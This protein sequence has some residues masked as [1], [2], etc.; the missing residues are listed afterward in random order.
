MGV[1][2]RIIQIL[3]SSGTS[4]EF[5]SLMC[6]GVGSDQNKLSSDISLS[7]WVN[8]PGLCC[9]AAGGD[10][11][12]ADD[13]AAV[14]LL[15][16]S[17]AHL[18]DKV[19][20]QDEPDPWWK[21]LGPGIALSTATGLFFSASLALNLLAQ[22]P[23]ARSIAAEISEDF[24]RRLLWMADGQYHEL[25][26]PP[27][28]LDQYWVRAE[29]KSGFLFSLACKNGARLATSDPDILSKFEQLGLLIGLLIQIADDLEDV[30]P[31]TGSNVPGQRKE[32]AYSL[33]AI[34]TLSVAPADQQAQLN[35]LLS[36]AKT[37]PDAA[38]EAI[39]LMNVAGATTYVLFELNRLSHQANQTIQIITTPGAARH[40]LNEL[41]DKL[42]NPIH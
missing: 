27:H 24:N 3:E 32:L 4:D 13:L 16:Y 40:Q 12:W 14:W 15:F 37:D 22:N 39:R 11:E 31:A 7:R 41:V 10:P 34:Y 42:V 29:A 18:M 38:T 6:H 25:T 1:A 20:D 26:G 5:I 2:N 33:P 21:D 35:K 8:L 36:S 23:L 30:L 17:A 9:Q 28:T 19:Q